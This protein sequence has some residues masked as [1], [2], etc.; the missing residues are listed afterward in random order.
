[1]TH[2]RQVDAD[3][4][5]EEAIDASH[6]VRV[7]LGEVIV[8]RD[9]VH[10]LSGQGV[11]IRRKCG[12]QCLALAGLH[13]GDLAVVQNHAAKEL[14]VEDPHLQRPLPR[15]ADDGERF[16]QHGVELLAV[17]DA[18]AQRDRARA[19]F[20]VGKRGGRRLQGIDPANGL[21]ILLE[22]ALVTAAEYFGENVGDH[23]SIADAAGCKKQGV[24]IPS[25]LP[26]I[27]A[28]LQ[29]SWQ[30]AGTGLGSGAPRSSAPRNAGAARSP[31]RSSRPQRSS[32]H[33]G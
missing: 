28:L 2:L 21:S 10:A 29:V 13:L 9:D 19:Q 12:D 20:V 24:R 16:R 30:T 33:G 14:H 31:V 7:A 22:Q 6:P 32:D 3:G 23:F 27:G 17:A 1:M 26:I 8:D 4:E 25:P 11:E 15:L 5:P 18:L